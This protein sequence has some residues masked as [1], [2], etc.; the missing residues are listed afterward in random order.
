MLLAIDIGNTETTIG[1]FRDETLVKRWRLTTRSDRTPDE[2]RT[3][4][5]QLLT[6]DRVSCDA[7]TNVAISCV[8]PPIL[9]T[10]TEMVKAQFS[11]EPMVVGPGIKTGMPILYDSPKEVGAD[12]IVNAVAAYSRF[13]SELILVDFGTATTFDHVTAKGEYAGGTIV[14]GI[15]I[16]AN[17][18]FQNTAKLPRVEIIQ[19]ARV[20]G[21]NT[22]ESIQS[23]L[24]YGYASMVD[25]MVL[26]MTDEIQTRATV[27]A[28]GG[29]APRIA[30]AART[31]QHVIPELTLEGLRILFARNSK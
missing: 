31:I 11:T 15:Q 8:V 20:I 9:P 29:L 19:P 25:G 3:Q 13:P 1:V 16:A 17:A 6:L 28:T 14:P 12:R 24:Y 2:L 30:T 27:V 10:Y 4:F 23:G 22:V 7:I 5:N 21:R 18:L 26:R